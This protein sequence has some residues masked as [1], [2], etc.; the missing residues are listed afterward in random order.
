MTKYVIEK[1]LRHHIIE[2][3]ATVMSLIGALLISFK[4]SQGYYIWIIG[5]VLWA[6]FAY[7]HKHYGLLV[8]SIAYFII[9]IIGIIRW[10]F[11]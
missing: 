6:S 7:K 4:F 9:N 3:T 8:L 10:Q 2:W 11:F 1:E 5:N